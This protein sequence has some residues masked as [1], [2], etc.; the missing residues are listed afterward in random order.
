L[1]H[2]K[3]KE[4][5]SLVEASEG[6]KGGQISGGTTEMKRLETQV[7]RSYA[8]TARGDQG[9]FDALGSQAAGEDA[10]KSIKEGAQF[11]AENLSWQDMERLENQESIKEF[12]LSLQKQISSCLRRLEVGWGN[13]ENILDQVAVGNGLKIG[14]P[15]GEKEAGLGFVQPI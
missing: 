12:L 9:L 8:E 6:K 2:E 14:V 1:Y 5:V 13:K 11:V 3:Q 4:T 15:S 10:S 7:Q